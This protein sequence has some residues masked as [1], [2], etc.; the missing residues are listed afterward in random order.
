MQLNV[1]DNTGQA[2]EAI[3]VAD[4]VFDTEFN[5][6]LVHQMA[7]AYRAAARAGTHAQ[8]NRAAVRGGGAKPYRQ[9]GMGRARAGTR[10]SPLFRSGGQIFA[11]SPRDYSQKVNRKSYR[12]AMRSV[13]SELQ[14]RGKLVVVSDLQF[15]SPKTGEMAA[16]LSQMNCRS[17]LI[18]AE[19]VDENLL[20]ATRNI[21]N[22]NV[23]APTM[24]NPANAVDCKKLLMTV[25]AVKSI[26]KWLQ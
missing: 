2:K 1:V 14:R 8:K 3:D 12:Q 23:I 24:L 21:P 5:N 10:S 16:R 11:A 22:V 26:E 6:A 4:S 25:D 13:L 20:L 9:K 19:Q 18:V 15:D 7:V 17:A